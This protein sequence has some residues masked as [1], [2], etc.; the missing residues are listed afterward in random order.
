MK[1]F[2]RP[3]CPCQEITVTENVT[4]ELCKKGLVFN[5]SS[6]WVLSPCWGC[7][8][9]VL[10]TL[11]AIT[12]GSHHGRVPSSFAWADTVACLFRILW[13]PNPLLETC[14][15]PVWVNQAG[16]LFVFRQPHR[17]G[18]SLQDK[19]PNREFLHHEMQINILSNQPFLH[20]RRCINRPRFLSSPLNHEYTNTA[21]NV[22][23]EGWNVSYWSPK[24]GHC[25]TTALK[26]G[27]MQCSPQN[28]SRFRYLPMTCRN[29][30][31]LICESL[32]LKVSSCLTS[33]SRNPSCN[34]K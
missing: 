1:I 33:P 4:K 2:G 27:K 10:V 11:S 20:K 3:N 25:W 31:L 26:S 17:V 30:V 16:Q 9:D 8:C 5:T 29:S 24:R 12:T 34:F 21:G 23:L 6:S 18:N 7:G 15:R 32:M 19:K 13:Q 22:V 14:P 28:C